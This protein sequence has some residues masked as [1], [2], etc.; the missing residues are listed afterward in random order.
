MHVLTMTS[1]TGIAGG[2]TGPKNIVG[3]FSSSF[4]AP[5]RATQF[6]RMAMKQ[7]IT[8]KGVVHT[9]NAVH[10]EVECVSLRCQFGH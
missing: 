3:T 1:V 10:N 8:T 6:Q 5:L 4:S 9:A 7:P 2:V